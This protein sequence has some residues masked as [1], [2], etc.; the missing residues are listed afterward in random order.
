VNADFRGKAPRIEFADVE[1][2][3]VVRLSTNNDF[4]VSTTRL[5]LLYSTLDVRVAQVALAA[6]VARRCGFVTT[7][8]A[9]LG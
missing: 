2:S 4:A 1:S 7:S 3:I 9:F 6:G 8:N 5:L